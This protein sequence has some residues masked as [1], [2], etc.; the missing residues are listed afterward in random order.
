VKKYWLKQEIHSMEQSW[1]T[2]GQENLS[3]VIQRLEPAFSEW[4]GERSRNHF[5]VVLIDLI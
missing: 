3:H 2:G 1:V 4:A 5:V